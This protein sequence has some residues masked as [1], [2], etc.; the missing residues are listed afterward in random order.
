M[1]DENQQLIKELINVTISLKNE[2]K[3]LNKRLENKVV[4]FMIKENII[5][6]NLLFNTNSYNNPH[7]RYR[8]QPKIENGLVIVEF[9]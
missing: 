4:K 7:K 5:D 3:K 1:T 2:I 9:D 8:S 6:N